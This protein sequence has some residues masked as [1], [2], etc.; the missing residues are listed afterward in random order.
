MAHMGQINGFSETVDGEQLTFISADVSPGSSGGPVINELGLVV[1]VITQSNEG[2]Y[3]IG[4][5]Q[6]QVKFRSVHHAAIPA[7]LV[8]RFLNEMALGKIRS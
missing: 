6:G 5:G 2:E 8:I 7:A 3:L 1:G 4:K